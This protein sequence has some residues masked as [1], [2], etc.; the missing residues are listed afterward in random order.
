[1]MSLPVVVVVKS[2]RGWN[3]INVHHVNIMQLQVTGGLRGVSRGD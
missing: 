1:M 3:T 2:G